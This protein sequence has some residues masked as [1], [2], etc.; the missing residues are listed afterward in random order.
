MGQAYALQREKL[1]KELSFILDQE[2]EI[3]NRIDIQGHWIDLAI[4]KPEETERERLIRTGKITPFEKPTQDPEHVFHSD[5]SYSEPEDTVTNLYQGDETDEASRQMD[6]GNEDYYQA[7]YKKWAEKRKRRRMACDANLLQDLDLDEPEHV[8]PCVVHEDAQFHGGFKIPGDIYSHLF[9]YQRTCTKW[10]WELHQQEVGGI[11]GDEMGLGKTIQIISF[12]AGLG[13]SKALNG[14]IL[15]VCPATVLRQW[16]QEF[17]KWWP[18]YRVAILHAS[19]S[20][21]L[22]T[23][24]K[25]EYVSDSEEEL[26]PQV[27][28]SIQKLLT[29]IAKHGHVL[30]TTYAG[31]R[32]YNEAIIDVKWHYVVLD[33][34]HKIRNPD[35][36]VTLAC[37][38]LK[39]PHR[40]I[41]SG[42]PIQNNLTELW[43]LYDFVFPGR[44]G[45]L[46]V[47]QS[48]FSIPISIGGYSN[49]NNIQ[50]QTAYKCACILRDLISPYLLR[51]VKAD[52]A[53]DLPKK[54]EQVLFC[55]LSEYQRKVILVNIDL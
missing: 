53:Q 9:P 36:E 28:K 17:H 23:K 50:V 30:I 8:L 10:L 47:F 13:Y 37:K 11:I 39:T 27:S 45:T 14:P 3:Q 12:L 6:D 32:L 2:K 5:G 7:R 35:A 24:R 29:H 33:E 44:L 51:R 52:V 42:T 18:A 22:D 43:S 21:R 1:E 46:P 48:Q 25:Y 41:L 19:G 40:I 49:A 38:R 15:V 54:D 55:K 4:S 26:V 20:A 31:V 34:G 16:V